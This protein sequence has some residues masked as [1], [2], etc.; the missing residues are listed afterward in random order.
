MLGCEHDVTAWGCLQDALRPLQEHCSLLA[1]LTAGLFLFPFLSFFLFC[2]WFGLV[3][4]GGWI[5]V[6]VI[7]VVIVVVVLRQGLST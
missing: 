3:V 2:V 7:V 5:V 1:S 4:L 6:V